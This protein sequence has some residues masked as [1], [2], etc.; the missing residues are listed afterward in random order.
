MARG[1][2][3]AFKLGGALSC[4]SQQL[5]RMLAGRSCLL[6]NANNSLSCAFQRSLGKRHHEPTFL[7][8]RT[9]AQ[10]G[11]LFDWLEPG[12]AT[13][14]AESHKAK[15]SQ[16][17]VTVRSG[18]PSAKAGEDAP[19]AHDSH[20]PGHWQHPLSRSLRPADN[21]GWSYI[22]VIVQQVGRGPIFPGK[23][24][25]QQ[26]HNESLLAHNLSL[27]MA[28]PFTYLNRSLCGPAGP[29]QAEVM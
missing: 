17:N 8:L 16:Y 3:A 28:L 2:G 20:P 9:G 5:M 6:A 21:V 27:H 14:G 10:R 18:R 19:T 23:H 29:S 4:P 1:C 26:R 25:V 22:Q 24:Q 7:M 12:S 15:P 13:T 11:S